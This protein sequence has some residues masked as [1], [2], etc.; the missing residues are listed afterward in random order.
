MKDKVKDK[1]I[2]TLLGV[3]SDM[4]IKMWSRNGAPRG[5]YAFDHI[6]KRFVGVT[7]RS[8]VVQRQ[9]DAQFEISEFPVPV[10]R[11]IKSWSK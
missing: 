6:R 5:I 8:A 10:R 4:E 3:P 11:E 9:K 7:L 1:V 2:H